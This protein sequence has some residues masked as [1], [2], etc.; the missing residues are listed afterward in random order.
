M[1]EHQDAILVSR[2]VS[3]ETGKAALIDV[4]E[5]PGEGGEVT[6]L[7]AYIEADAEVTADQ[8]RMIGAACLDTADD[9]DMFTTGDPEQITDWVR[10]LPADDPNNRRLKAL[11]GLV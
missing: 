1:N 6:S 9:I 4:C 8:L 5:R 10:R 3:T 7:Y 2:E 11:V